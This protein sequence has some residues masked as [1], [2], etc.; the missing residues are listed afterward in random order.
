MDIHSLSWLSAAVASVAVTKS[1]AVAP[2]WGPLI[3]QVAGSLGGVFAG[4]YLVN[5]RER[6]SKKEKKSVEALYLAVTV[7]AVLDKFVADC[8]DV[9]ADDGTYRGE[10]DYTHDNQG[11]RTAQEKAPEL[12]YAGLDVAW[13]SLP[14]KL[15][16][17]VHALPRK[18]RSGRRYLAYVHDNDGG[19]YDDYFAARQLKYAEL[20][21]AADEV[22]QELRKSVGLAP[23]GDPDSTTS[24]WLRE[25]LAELKGRAEVGLKEQARSSA[26]LAALAAASSPTPAN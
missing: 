2:W 25:R 24:T 22:T 16:D 6:E 18:L 4:A 10:L 26:E 7:S 14:A 3:I 1:I 20:G 8:A 17:A 9:A 23:A 15:L 21:V 19:P 11:V 13:V 5:R 12:D